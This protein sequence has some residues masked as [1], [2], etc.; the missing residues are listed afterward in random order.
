MVGEPF[1]SPSVYSAQLRPSNDCAI[2]GQFCSQVVLRFETAAT[3]VLGG[4]NGDLAAIFGRRAC[5]ALSVLQL[6][7]S[8]HFQ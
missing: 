6:P 5:L 2:D 8:E 1:Q 3:A 7:G 4:E